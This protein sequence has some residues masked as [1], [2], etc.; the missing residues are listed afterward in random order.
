MDQALGLQQVSV[1]CWQGGQ[2][3]VPGL[4]GHPAGAVSCC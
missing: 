3:R 1:V 2:H 4:Q